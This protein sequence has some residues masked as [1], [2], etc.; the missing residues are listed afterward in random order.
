LHSG[1]YFAIINEE[2]I[3]V[4]GSSFVMVTSIFLALI[5]IFHEGTYP[6]VFVSTWFFVQFNI[7]IL[8]YG[9]GLLTRMKKLGISMILLFLVATLVAVLVPCLLQLQLK[10]GE[11]QQ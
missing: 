1:A 9:I 7:A 11:F 4:I 10:P 8:T 2:K 3:G 5:G 6:H